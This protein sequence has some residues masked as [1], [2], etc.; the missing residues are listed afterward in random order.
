MSIPVTMRGVQLIGHGGPDKLVWNDAIPVP[1][2]GPE[3]ALVKVTAAGV[4]NTDINTRIGWYAKEVTGATGESDTGA[5]VEAGGWSG[6]LRFPRIQGADLCGRVVALGDRAPA[7][8]QVGMRVTCPTNQPEPTE[9]AP[10][11][12]QALG[13][14]LDGAFAQYCRVPARQ[15][16]D[17]T[18]SPLTDIEVA[19]IPCAHGTAYNLI[20]R[21]GVDA[22]DR[23]LIT[24]ASGGVGLA[25]VQLAKIRGAHV[26]AVA[27]KTK[28]DAVRETGADALL[29]RSEMPAP[30][31][32]TVAIDVVGG[33]GWG[34]V[35]DALVP[36]GRYATSGAT[37]GP[38]VEAD[39]RTIYLNDL[40]IFGCTYTP[41]ETF[42]E[43]V[44]LING[45]RV[46]PLISKTY[47]LADIH[48]AQADFQAKTHPG[49][50]V[51]LPPSE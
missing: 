7:T 47:D 9:D 17:V 24:G 14:E 6:A 44:E 45:G 21:A 43:L 49:K 1:K 28:Q 37:A 16:H 36:G 13:S 10:T 34:A 25:A 5:D 26:T 23:V 11:R 27:S 51:L 3:D 12:F 46:R 32:F 42:A 31:S 8:L 48:R 20:S 33:A 30:A 2:I 19:A 41:R 15:L 35:I 50:L 40:T 39:L 38:I 29:D 22:S 18:R 4:N